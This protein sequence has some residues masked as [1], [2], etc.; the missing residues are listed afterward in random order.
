ME[1][2]PTMHS[3]CCLVKIFVWVSFIK[4]KKF[5]VEIA[6][7]HLRHFLCNK[8]NSFEHMAMLARKFYVNCTHLN[9]KQKKYLRNNYCDL[10]QFHSSGNKCVYL[11]SFNFTRCMPISDTSEI[12]IN[13]HFSALIDS[14]LHLGLNSMVK[15]SHVK[16]PQQMKLSKFNN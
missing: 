8:I 13:F 16:F 3:Q 1:F 5:I 9:C 14:S 12:S 2:P 10:D 4:H 7:I 6:K 15:Q 11:V